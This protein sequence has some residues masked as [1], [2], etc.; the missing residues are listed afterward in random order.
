[1]DIIIDPRAAQ[2][3]PIAKYGTREN[4]VMNSS[5]TRIT[6]EVF[7]LLTQDRE[8]RSFVEYLS[9]I[10]DEYLYLTNTFK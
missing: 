4:A 6:R 9:R 5:F 8:I 10:L 1:L 3:C 7:C 2:V